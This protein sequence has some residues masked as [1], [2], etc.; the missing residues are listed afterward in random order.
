MSITYSLGTLAMPKFLFALMLAT[1]CLIAHAADSVMLHTPRGAA[2][3][4]HAEFPAGAG[5]FPAVILAPGQGYHM[6]LPIMQKTAEHLVAEGFAVYRFNWAY[7]TRDPKKGA[8]SDDL[9]PEVE[10][11]ATVL[12]AARSDKRVDASRIS[13]AGKSLGSAVA[14]RL[15]RQEAAL[16]KGAFLTPICVDDDGRP[17]PQAVFTNYPGSMEEKRPV[18]FI[19][20][21]QDPLCANPAL[22]RF[23]DLSGGRMRIAVVAGNH[24]FSTPARSTVDDTRTLDVVTRWVAG[25]LLDADAP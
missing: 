7:F 20:G 17:D 12:T 22:Y 19:S 24:V 9:S 16:R 25:F 11:M 6:D 4:M 5:P 2:L 13:A 3:A 8:P 15:F 21:D 23:A 18:A 1:A 14:W 10:D